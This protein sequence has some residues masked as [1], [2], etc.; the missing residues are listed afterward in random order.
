MGA[1]GFFI[2]FFKLERGECGRL[3]SYCPILCEPSG[4][5]KDGEYLD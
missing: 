5:V 1:D 2:Y 4:V 3:D